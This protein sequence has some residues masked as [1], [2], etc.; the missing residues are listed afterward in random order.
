MMTD[1]NRKTLFDEFPPV[2]TSDWQRQIEADLKGRDFEKV[3]VWKTNEGFNVRPYYRAEDLENIQFINSLPGQFPYVRGNRTNGN[4]WFIR[5]DIQVTTPEEANKKALEVLQKG[6]NSL[7][8]VF[9]GCAEVTV[10]DLEVLLKDV[11]LDA[12]EVNLVS[13]CKSV[14]NGKALAQYIVKKYGA[15]AKGCCF[16]KG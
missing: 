13:C 2:S 14:N 8:F 7:G 1:K 10:A 9:K 15:D 11:S 12:I 6:I 16:G 4:E 5:Q 3:L